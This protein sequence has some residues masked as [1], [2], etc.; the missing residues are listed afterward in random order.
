MQE[1]LE[2]K[3]GI[4]G[5]FLQDSREGKKKLVE[6]FLIT[7]MEEE[8]GIQISSLPYERSEDRKGNRNGSR[9][10]KLKT[11]ERV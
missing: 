9:T 3:K 11:T 6:W 8:A 2:I 1:Q 4:I 10:K 5:I 7:V